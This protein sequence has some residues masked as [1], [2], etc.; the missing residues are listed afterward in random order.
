MKVAFTHNLRVTDVRESEKDAEFDSVETVA[1]IAAAI[2][3]AGHEVEKVEVSGPAS[4]LLE[5]LEA[6]DPDIIFNTAEGQ[7]GKMRE[8]L[9]PALFEELGIPYTGSDGY[10]NALTLDKWLTKLIVQRAGIDT[11]RGT[12]VHARNFETVV[13]RGV[14]LA[15]PVIVKPNYEGSSKGIYNSPDS[16]TVRG[17]SSAVKEPRDLPAKLQGFSG[18]ESR[19]GPRLGDNGVDLRKAVE[20]FENQL[21]RQ[22]LEKTNW[23]KKRA[24]ELLGIN[25]TTLVEMLKRK[26]IEAA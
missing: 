12:M 13:E 3:A 6:I 19:T 22:A 2:E 14:G 24:A 23:N 1:A 16:N 21:I 18:T 5:R 10:T 4:N 26:R 8:A 9:Y 15:F 25:R 20:G 17:P 11:P 7:T